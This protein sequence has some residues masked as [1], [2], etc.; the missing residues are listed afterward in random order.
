METGKPKLFDG[1]KKILNKSKEDGKN[2]K[3]I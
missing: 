2:Y 1:R 3:K